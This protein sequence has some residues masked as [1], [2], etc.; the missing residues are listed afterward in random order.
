MQARPNLEVAGGAEGWDA[1]VVVARMH[2]VD[3]ECA[4]KSQGTVGSGPVD[5]MNLGRGIG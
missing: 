1:F 4:R 3:N 2:R 5:W